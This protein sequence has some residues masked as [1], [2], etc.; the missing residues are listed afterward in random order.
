MFGEDSSSSHFII[1]EKKIKESNLS[2]QSYSPATLSSVSLLPS[3]EY[4]AKSKE[5]RVLM[6]PARSRKEKSNITVLY[7][8]VK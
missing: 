3:S 7:L 8:V 6:L 4:L 1:S 2:F 5:S